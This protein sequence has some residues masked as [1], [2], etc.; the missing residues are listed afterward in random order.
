MLVYV[1]FI[2][3]VPSFILALNFVCN[4]FMYMILLT[5]W[6]VS[7]AYLLLPR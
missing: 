5:V 1:S 3:V 4:S 6:H 2:I 7:G